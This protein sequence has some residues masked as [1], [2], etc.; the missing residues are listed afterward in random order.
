VALHFNDLDIGGNGTTNADKAAMS[1]GSVNPLNYLQ[2]IVSR[3]LQ[4]VGS[5]ANKINNSLSGTDALSAVAQAP[6]NGRLSPFV[7][8]MNELQQLQQTD[9]TKYQQVTQQIATSLQ[10]A[11]QTAQAQGNT[12]AATQLGQLATDFTDAS[13][14]GQLP[15]IQDL[16]QAVG[17]QHHHHHHHAHAA[18]AN[19]D[20][21]AST[22][23]STSSSTASSDAS[24]TVNQ[25]LAAFQTGGAQ[26]DALN[27]MSI[28][29]STLSSAGIGGSNG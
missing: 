12:T 19:S 7:Q 4:G 20:S 1:I 11:S 23:S 8:M 28:I 27:P 18:A 25:L 21:T 29:M 22:S 17:G 24:Q 15:N 3:A 16:A 26:S 2:S 14:S 9:P 5:T 6:D 13:K 10:S